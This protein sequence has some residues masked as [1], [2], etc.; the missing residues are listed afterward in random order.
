VPQVDGHRRL[1][2]AAYQPP[3]AGACEQP[4]ACRFGREQQA[5]QDGRERKHRDRRRI[6]VLHDLAGHADHVDG[7]RSPPDQRGQRDQ[8]ASGERVRK[9]AAAGQRAVLP[10]E[11]ALVYR[12][13]A[14]QVVGEADHGHPP[15]D[16]GD[17]HE[18]GRGCHRGRDGQAEPPVQAEQRWGEQDEKQVHRQEP[19]L[20]ADEPGGLREFGPA[21]SGERGADHRDDGGDHVQGR[22]PQQPERPA[23]HPGR[24][25]LM[26]GT[27][28]GQRG[29]VGEA[30]DHEEHGHDLE[31]QRQPAPPGDV[32]ERVDAGQVAAQ[33]GDVGGQPVADD[34]ES[35]GADTQQVGVP[36]TFHA[37]SGLRLPSV[38]ANHGSA[39]GL[40]AGRPVSGVPRCGPE[41][42]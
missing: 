25:R 26:S 39:S 13:P 17:V 7:E 16:H 28:G 11:A 14:E 21:E 32:A 40:A 5:D 1:V 33:V 42:R 22:R 3:P 27:M 2:E 9:P 34:H 10:G 36:I 12:A 18:R 38:L 24:K 15:A 29:R 8:S 19:Q 23:A 31:D 30:A 35:Y 37:R 6:R 4:L 41:C 20:Q